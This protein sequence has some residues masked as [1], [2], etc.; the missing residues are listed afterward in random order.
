[1]TIDLLQKMPK[2]T[3]SKDAQSI[4]ITLYERKFFEIYLIYPRKKKG[5]FSCSG[6]CKYFLYKFSVPFRNKL[7]LS[8]Q[9]RRMVSVIWFLFKDL[10][11]NGIAMQV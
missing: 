1:M 7:H 11:E 10:R 8:I 5:I 4:Y 6:A 3:P 9:M 2:V